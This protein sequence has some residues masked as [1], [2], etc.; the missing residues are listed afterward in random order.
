MKI[1][2][3]HVAEPKF[4][5][6]NDDDTNGFTSITAAIPMFQTQMGWDIIFTHELLP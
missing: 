6:K 4:F 2:T 3:C 1:P 5:L